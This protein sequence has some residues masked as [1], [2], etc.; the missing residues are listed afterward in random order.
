MRSPIRIAIDGAQSTG[1]T[2][3]VARLEESDG[4]R[5]SYISEASRAIASRFGIAFA[6]DWDQ[7]IADK[8]QL[9]RFFDCEERWQRAKESEA[10]D[11]VADGS[12]LLTAIYRSYF[13]APEPPLLV[14]PYD[15]VLYCS[16]D[17]PFEDD[18][19]RFA[20]G[21]DEIDTLYRRNVM[22]V[23][24]SRLVLL[25]FGEPRY[26]HAHSAIDELL[27]RHCT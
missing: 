21:R 18:G 6:G 23:L 8:G 15:L 19:F 20:R 5:L 24:G 22:G 14:P 17:L 27:A 25:P 1:K 2:T 26:P 7:L 3:L 16:P 12:L 11:F 9:S 4:T 10:H 13:R